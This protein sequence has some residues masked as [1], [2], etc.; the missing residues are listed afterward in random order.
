MNTVSEDQRNMAMKSLA[1]TL[2]K[3]KRSLESMQD[4]GSS[5]TLVRKR[6]LAVH[7]GLASLENDWF[8]QDFMFDEATIEASLETLKR[9]AS[10]V[11]KQRTSAP[12]HSSQETLMDR[13]G[14]ALELAIQSLSKR[15]D[16]YA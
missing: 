10:A 1:S 8:T 4:Q 2:H 7:V 9:I 15:L 5:T 11:E 12:R 3:L 6:L 13:R 16:R 14:A